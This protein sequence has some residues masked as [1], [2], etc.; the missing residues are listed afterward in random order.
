LQQ[1][2]DARVKSLE[3]AR[4]KLEGMLASKRQLAVQV[5]NLQARLQMLSA[6]QSTSEYQFD[7][8]RLGRTK[9]LVASLKSR[10]DVAEKLVNA[11]TSFHGEIQLDTPTPENIAQEVGEYFGDK[12]TK[13]AGK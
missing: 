6:A 1:I 9:E 7:D 2:H 3:A 4:Q 10:L 13:L 8:S 12:G 5:E 11:E